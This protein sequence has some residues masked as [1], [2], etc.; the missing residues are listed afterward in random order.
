MIKQLAEHLGLPIKAN[1]TKAVWRDS[2][3][4]NI[5][6]YEEDF[7]DFA[8]S[9]KG[10]DVELVKLVKNIGTSEA[11]QY[12]RDNNFR[13]ESTPE[14]ADVSSIMNIIHPPL[15]ILNSFNI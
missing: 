15:N 8:T 14:P 7:Y 10:N 12:L 11:I 13:K 1:R 4:W 9:S 5:E 2:N 6:L 3:S